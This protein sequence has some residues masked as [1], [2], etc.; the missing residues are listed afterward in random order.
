MKINKID[1]KRFRVRNKLKKVSD[2][3]RYRVTIFR[4]KK[5]FYQSNK[6]RNIASLYADG[7]NQE[8]NDRFL[9]ES[10]ILNAYTRNLESFRWKKNN[11]V[12]H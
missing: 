9:R 8:N 6:L 12:L 10:I 7:R 4:S 11:Q 2:G 1:R 3:S 5:N